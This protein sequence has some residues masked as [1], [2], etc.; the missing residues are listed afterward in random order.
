MNIYIVVCGEYSDFHIE[1][2]FK[3]KEDA[4]NYCFNKNDLDIVDKYDCYRIQEYELC[5]TKIPKNFEQSMI[6][7]VA[8]IN[9]ND[10]GITIYE[11]IKGWSKNEE[12]IHFSTNCYSPKRIK[13]EFL[14]R[15]M[16]EEKL[17]KII[18]DEYRKYKYM[19]EL[20]GK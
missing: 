16:S 4:E 11:T 12:Y 20:E 3:N 18:A 13:V 5:E 19:K 7:G 8:Y 15:E 9:C 6:E 17:I 2:V 10:G 14:K 1:Q